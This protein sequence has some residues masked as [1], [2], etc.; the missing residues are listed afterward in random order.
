MTID[1]TDPAAY[2]WPD[3]CIDCGDRLCGVCQALAWQDEDD[4]RTR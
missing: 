4:R 1:P 3:I 2:A